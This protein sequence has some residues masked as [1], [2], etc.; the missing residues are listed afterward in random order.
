[1]NT[2]GAISFS[3]TL[4]TYTPSPFPLGGNRKIVAPYWCDI[5]TR[6]GG[7]VWYYETNNQD[8]LRNAS[9]NIKE[10][11]PGQ[12]NFEAAWVFVTTWDNVAFYGSSSEGQKKVDLLGRMKNVC[13]I[14]LHV[15]KKCILM[16][17][18]F[19]C[20]SILKYY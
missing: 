4:S 18:F 12:T 16:F 17:T 19:I 14:I 8:L 20:F 5:D 10:I 6:K 7:D 3:Q 13:F 2:N 9:E 11:F 15:P 1:M